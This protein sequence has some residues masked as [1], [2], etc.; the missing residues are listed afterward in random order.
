MYESVI[1]GGGPAGI[2]A[3]VYLARKKIRFL[4]ITENIGGQTLWSGSIENYVGYQYISGP[5]L[6]EKFYAHLRDFP[7]DLKEG[8]RVTGVVHDSGIFAVSSDKGEYR[9]KTAVICTGSRANEINVP[10][11]KNFKNRGITYCA[12]C[13]GPLFTG[14]DVAVIG[15]GNSGVESALQ[16]VRIAKRVYLIEKKL[17]LTA[18]RIL[19]D[20]LVKERTC[21]I[22]TDTAVE[23]IFGDKFVRG[24]SIRM[25]GDS[26]KE[27]KLAVEGVLIEIGTIP[28]SGIIEG[29]EKNKA[30]EII[31]DCSASTSIPGLFAAGDVTNVYKKQIIIACGEGAKA[32]IAVSEYLNLYK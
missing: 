16:M 19:A 14:K 22:I 30:G 13:D 1:I 21:E 25:G 11:E 4:I 17:H 5:E 32:A 24:I 9:A 6:A 20:R 31:V 10:G 27:R 28:N 18:D 2:S 23:E 7:V 29:V 8:E 3:G 12:T 15:G 26:E